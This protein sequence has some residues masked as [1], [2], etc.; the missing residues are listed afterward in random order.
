MSGWWCAQPLMFT[1]YAPIY[2]N[3]ASNPLGSAVWSL[4]HPQPEKNGT[5]F[6]IIV[7]GSKLLYA[8]RGNQVQIL[9]LRH[10]TKNFEHILPA[11]KS[12]S[13]VFTST[14]LR[15]KTTR[16]FA[17]VRR[18]TVHHR[19]HVVRQAT[20]CLGYVVNITRL[21]TKRCAS[22]N[23]SPPTC[24]TSLIPDTHVIVP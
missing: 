2:S 17:F 19:E 24:F 12:M 5:S 16:T 4:L 20:P 6:N 3:C 9:H 1:I 10:H 14:C 11:A 7:K 15:R 18:K 22:A 13:K 21:T 23:I 8:K